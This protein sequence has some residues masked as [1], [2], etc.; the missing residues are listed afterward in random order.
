VVKLAL[1][2]VASDWYSLLHHQTL[3]LWDT[4]IVCSTIG[5]GIARCT[6]ERT[7]MVLVPPVGCNRE[8][9]IYTIDLDV[10]V[11]EEQETAVKLT[12]DSDAQDYAARFPLVTPDAKRLIYFTSSN[13]MT[14]GSAQ[15]ARIIE[16]ND[17]NTVGAARTLVDIVQV[18]NEQSQF[19]GLFFSTNLVSKPWL[20]DTQFVVTSQWR[21][22]HA[23]T[24][25]CSGEHTVALKH[26][27]TD[28][29]V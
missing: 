19:P 9:Y 24:H 27:E 6:I 25:H 23:S 2:L 12:S 26:A 5:S 17:D 15:R 20:S 14:H 16:F 8:S 29:R 28:G 22:R 1:C 7:D 21:S 4:S 10:A 18:S 13:T 3:T 11:A